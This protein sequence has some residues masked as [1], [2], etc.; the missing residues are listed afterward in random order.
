M[1]MR[2]KTLCLY[3]PREDKVLNVRKV[4]ELNI[5]YVEFEIRGDGARSIKGSCLVYC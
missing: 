4:K 3:Y 5:D 1:T 2:D